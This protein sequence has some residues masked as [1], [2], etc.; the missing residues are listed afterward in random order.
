MAVACKPEDIEVAA[1]NLD[2]SALELFIGDSQSLIATIEPENAT[3]KTLIWSSDN[4]KIAKVDQEGKLTIL[5]GPGEA[6]IT[7]RSSNGVTDTC[8]VIVRENHY[9]VTVNK[10]EINS[11][12]YFYNEEA[13]GYA[14]HFFND[15][16]P[17]IGE[18]GSYSSEFKSVAL[19]ITAEALGKECDLDSAELANT[20][21]VF[22]I[23][24]LD[25]DDW[26][27]RYYTSN[28]SS[29]NV[30]ID[31]SSDGILTA[32]VD[33]L[34]KDGAVFK[35]YYKGKAEQVGAY[36]TQKKD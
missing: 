35:V 25:S 7:V 2:N 22:Y 4:E 16:N 32:C 20:V 28:L 18:D 11:V 1:I 14:V 21:W 24:S 3:D 10:K 5:D 36:L 13:N 29:A 6:T 12:Y 31:L 19:Y 34:A 33:I 26:Y 30:K 27:D 9:A 15:A 8:S 17:V 23:E